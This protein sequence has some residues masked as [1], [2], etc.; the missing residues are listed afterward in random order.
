[1]E[2]VTEG[3]ETVAFKSL[4]SEWSAPTDFNFNKFNKD[5]VKKEDEPVDI[6]KLLSMMT[7]E[8]AP[9]DDGSGETLI[10]TETPTLKLTE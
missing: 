10:V 6:Q 5:A 1:V 2:R 7:L 4:F 9:V 3:V 8:A